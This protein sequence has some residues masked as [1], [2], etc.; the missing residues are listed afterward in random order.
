MEL[1]EAGVELK[2]VTMGAGMEIISAWC[3]VVLDVMLVTRGA[4]CFL[5]LEKGLFMLF[6]NKA[7]FC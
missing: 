2:E 6:A 1:K 5:V 4:P 7:L 3:H